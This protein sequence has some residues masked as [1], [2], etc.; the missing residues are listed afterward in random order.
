MVEG[1]ATFKRIHRV[2]Q[3]ERLSQ[4]TTCLGCVDILERSFSSFSILASQ[5][6]R[7]RPACSNPSGKRHGGVRGVRGG[8]GL[9]LRR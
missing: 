2:S 1:L 3:S 4:I 9:Y 6:N 8:L 5:R 7:Q